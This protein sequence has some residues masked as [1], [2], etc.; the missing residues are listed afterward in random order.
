GAPQGGPLSP[1]LANVALHG[2]ETAIRSAFP[3]D[4][5]ANGQV[6]WGWRPMVVR[7]ADDFVVLH[8]DRQVIEQTRQRAAERLGR[9]GL[10]VKPEKTQASHT[11]PPCQGRVGF[12]FLGFT[13]RQY[14]V[15]Y[16]RSGKL[17]LGFKTWITPSKASQRRQYAALASLVRRQRQAPQ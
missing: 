6:R 16:H 1:L 3:R 12:D 8:E 15:G 2:L 5:Y 9:I 10:A 13:V 4:L 14:R 17:R 7:Y 11:L